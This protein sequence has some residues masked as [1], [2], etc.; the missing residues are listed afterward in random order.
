MQGSSEVLGRNRRTIH[1]TVLNIAFVRTLEGMHV[2]YE[3]SLVCP[4]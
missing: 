3:T 1:R 2:Y 4:S